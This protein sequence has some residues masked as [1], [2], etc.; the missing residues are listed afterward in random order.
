MVS[1]HARYTSALRNVSITSIND[2]VWFLERILGDYDYSPLSM[3]EQTKMSVGSEDAAFLLQA[4]VVAIGDES[5]LNGY[6]GGIG[7]YL[8]DKDARIWDKVDF[9]TY[10]MH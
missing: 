5:V 9:H 7:Y 3:R 6:D 10:V 2:S 8:W 4:F 1:N